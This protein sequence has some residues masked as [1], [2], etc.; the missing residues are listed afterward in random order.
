[1]PERMIRP[2]A[3][4]R[5]ATRDALADYLLLRSGIHPPDVDPVAERLVSDGRGMLDIAAHLAGYPAGTPGGPEVYR[6][7]N[8][9]DFGTALEVA[10]T[11]AAMVSYTAQ[12]AEYAVIVRDVEIRDLRPVH[13]PTLDLGEL[14]AIPKAGG[15]IQT[16]V[17][18]P[19]VGATGEAT[20]FSG[21][22]TVSRRLLIDD[23]AG[24]IV[25]AVQ[26]LVGHAARLEAAAIAS[27]IAA[28]A[29]IDGTALI[30]AENTTAGG[31]VTDTGVGAGL[32]LLRTRT[33]PAG[34]TAN[35]RGAHLLVHPSD[36][37]LALKTVASISAPSSVRLSVV[38]NPWLG[39]GA[40][41]LLADPAAAPVFN[42]LLLSVPPRPSVENRRA[43]PNMDGTAYRVSHVFGITAVGRQG[44]VKVT[45]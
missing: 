29:A 14:Q 20:L 24:L 36:E 12:V 42:R 4:S 40:S 2:V 3:Y 34:S 17:I 25:G 15:P 19:G 11:S 30:T 41:Y 43:P 22:F 13:F 16:P 10:L 5:A 21:T 1:M 35:I 33:T 31:A 9:S 28:N 37:L 23:E 44:I 26:Q 38:V 27:A 7:L 8:G 6:A 39:T 18:V 32:A 45:T